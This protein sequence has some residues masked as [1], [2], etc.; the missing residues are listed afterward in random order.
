MERAL[1][2]GK[3]LRRVLTRK[4]LVVIVHSSISL[5]S[6]DL[7]ESTFDFVLSLDEGK[8]HEL[9]G[10]GPDSLARAFAISFTFFDQCIYLPNNT[11]ILKNCDV[12]FE[13]GLGERKKSGSLSPPTRSSASSLALH[14][15]PS[16]EAFKKVNATLVHLKK[17]GIFLKK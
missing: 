6:R 9:G 4:S 15:K 8:C 3:S 17:D 7:L 13:F 10:L 2:L 5:T 16:L 12:L 11:L 1:V 14:F